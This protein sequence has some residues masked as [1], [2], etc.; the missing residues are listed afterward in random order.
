MADG[1]DIIADE[2]VNENYI[3][4]SNKDVNKD[5][6]NMYEVNSVYSLIINDIVERKR[7]KQSCE[8]SDI[9]KI[10]SKHHESDELTAPLIQKYIDDLILQ[11]KITSKV[12][13]G[14]E[15]L[16][17]NNIG[18][19]YDCET[20]ESYS[21]TPNVSDKCSELVNE[22]RAEVSAIKNLMFDELW[23]IR[24]Q[25]KKGTSDA[26]QTDTV[27]K[28]WTDSMAAEIGFL[29]DEIVNKNSIIKDLLKKVLEKNTRQNQSS[30]SCESNS[31]NKQADTIDLLAQKAIIVTNALSPS[32]AEQSA[33]KDLNVNVHRRKAVSQ[34]SNLHDFDFNT[35]KRK[36][37]QTNHSRNNLN[38]HKSNNYI[39][40]SN[41]FEV[42]AEGLIPVGNDTVELN[43]TINGPRST[44]IT[45][46]NN[47]RANRKTIDNKVTVILGDSIVKNIKGYQMSKSF[48][49][50]K[51]IVKSFAGA[52]TSCM[53]HYSKPTLEKSPDQIILHTGT[54]DLRNPEKNPLEIANEII[55]LAKSCIQENNTV[56]VSSITPRYDK[57]NQKA[58]DVNGYLEKEC[59]ARNI[60]F[61]NH[62]NINITRHL[63]ESKLHLNE[64]GTGILA[65]NFINFLK[66]M[67][68]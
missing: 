31:S 53:K 19:Q 45:N 66:Y 46:N 58:Q 14:K 15:R 5:T 28:I 25:I 23:H 39:P 6:D 59:N 32:I 52:T 57:L 61:I 11:K 62:N 36:Q 54:N 42:L 16:A 22:L 20:D 1:R 47:T 60:G 49:S 8:R 44:N 41:S 3:A 30:I 65:K 64:M 12:Y 2:L 26:G 37:S 17:I 55:D 29:R 33:K 21:G 35:V 9:V 56:F 10:I 4:G 7:R 43:N 40:T 68:N 24:E 27:T 67:E 38:T 18:E 50:K 48:Q 13:A 51:V 34:D 63:N